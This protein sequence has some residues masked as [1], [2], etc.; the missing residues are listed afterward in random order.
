MKK[1]QSNSFLENELLKFD[2]FNVDNILSEIEENNIKKVSSCKSKIKLE[3]PKTSRI[4]CSVFMGII[5]SGILAWLCYGWYMSWIKYPREISISEENT[6]IFCL[7]EF[8]NK[9]SSLESIGDDSYISKEILYAN[10]DSYKI[11]FYKKVLSTVKYKG[12]PVVGKNIY[13]NTLVNRND[14]VVFTESTIGVGE[15]VIMQYIDYDRIPIDRNKISILMEEHDLKVGDVDYPNKLVDVFCEYV[16]GLNEKEIKIKSVKRIP[17]ITKEGNSYRVLQEEDI[18]LDR[19]LFSSNE[20]YEFMDRFSAVA[21][22]VGVK[23]PEWDVWNNLSEEEKVNLSEPNRELQCIQPLDKWLEWSNLSTVEKESVEEP[24]KYDWKKVLNKEWCGTYYLQNEYSTMDKDGNV[25]KKSIDAEIGDG[26]LEDP[27]GLNTDILTSIFINELDEE[28]NDVVN[29]YP[30]KVSM[31]DYGVSEDAINWFEEQDVRNRG[32]DVTSEVQYV[33]YTFEV[34]NMS[35]KEITITDNSSLS[36]KNANITSRTGIMYGV[37]DSITLKPDT[38]GIIESW[39]RSTEL[40]KRYVLWGA[41]FA[42]RADPIWFRVLAG[43]IDDSSE[44]KGVTINNSRHEST[45]ENKN[46]KN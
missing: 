34:T 37:E 8:E 9:L 30:I 5:F 23:N 11:N 43:D 13:G 29:E 10:N 25:V 7:N 16:T 17:Y 40:N 24:I 3:K 33:Y 1:E 39:S 31:L 14:E 22:S 42:R 19:L 15:P 45:E 41:D 44:N 18:Y 12:Y 26:T 2:D 38:S 4:V 46:I 36:D 6:G 21:S 28:G 35:D 20:L 32:L 27:A